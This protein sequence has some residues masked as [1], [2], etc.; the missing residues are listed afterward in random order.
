MRALNF[1][2]PLST[3]HWLVRPIMKYYAENPGQ[4]AATFIHVRVV[5]VLKE[6]PRVGV[7]VVHDDCEMG[8]DTGLYRSPQHTVY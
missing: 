6:K 2:Q 3:D 5:H 7:Y 1:K 4:L 8:T